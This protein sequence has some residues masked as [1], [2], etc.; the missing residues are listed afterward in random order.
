[1]DLILFVEAQFYRIYCAHYCNTLGKILEPPHIGYDFLRTYKIK[2]MYLYKDKVFY[3]LF[4]MNLEEATSP[5][6]PQNKK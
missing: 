4:S 3:R 1:M 2:L 5:I 6:L